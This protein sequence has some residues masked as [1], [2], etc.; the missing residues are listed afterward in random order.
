MYGVNPGALAAEGETRVAAYVEF[1]ETLMKVLFDLATAAED[2]YAFRASGKKFFEETSES[3][4]QER[5]A[6][7]A[8]VKAGK[9]TIE[10]MRRE[11][12][13]QP[14]RIEITQ[15]KTFTAKDNATDPHVTVAA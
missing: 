4:I 13:E 2:F 3:S 8:A 12:A 7:R 15:K 5:E 6:A 11:T 9:V 10:G 14:H 1:R